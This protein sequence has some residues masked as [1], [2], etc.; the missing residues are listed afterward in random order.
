MCL[1]SN[2]DTFVNSNILA[3]TAQISIYNKREFFLLPL[4]SLTAVQDCAVATLARSVFI[5]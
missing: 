2:T 3:Q 4:T 5:C 1:M